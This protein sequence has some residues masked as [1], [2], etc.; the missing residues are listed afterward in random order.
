[1]TSRRPQASD[2]HQRR[3]TEGIT[4]LSPAGML[5]PRGDL[6]T[7]TGAISP[8]RGNHAIR[9]TRTGRPHPAIPRRVRY[10]VRHL[11]C[12]SLGREVR[13]HQLPHR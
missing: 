10:M 5:C 7:E 6:N 12:A 9:V 13:W 8:D 4:T 2:W 1:M 11:A 3:V